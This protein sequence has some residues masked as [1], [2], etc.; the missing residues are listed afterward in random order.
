MRP[1]LNSRENGAP[2]SLLALA[3]RFEGQ[4]RTR[5]FGTNI[6][7]QILF[8]PAIKGFNE[9]NLRLIVSKIDWDEQ[10]LMFHK[11]TRQG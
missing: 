9:R 10:R 3:I 4:V 8:L 6:R 7:E 11:I 2:G 5:R 1:S